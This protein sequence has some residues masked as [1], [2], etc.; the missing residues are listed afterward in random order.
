[1]SRVAEQT[2]RPQVF[3]NSEEL[4]T[5]TGTT[6]DYIDQS[7]G[8]QDDVDQHTKAPPPTVEADCST[9]PVA[10]GRQKPDRFTSGSAGC[11]CSRVGRKG[12]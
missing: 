2:Q 12:C 3:D 1:M 10:R 9:L 8:W 6:D 4:P 5:E 11:N 7:L